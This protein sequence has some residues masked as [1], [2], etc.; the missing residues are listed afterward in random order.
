MV[1]TIIEAIDS[2]PAQLAAEPALDLKNYARNL[3]ELFDRATR[4]D[5]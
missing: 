5:T 1:V 2:I 3:V 4:T